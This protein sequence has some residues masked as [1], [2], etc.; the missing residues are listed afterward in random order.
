MSN[1]YFKLLFFTAR[2]CLIE[3]DI[4]GQSETETPLANKT[5]VYKTDKRK[6]PASSKLD[7][8]VFLWYSRKEKKKEQK[9]L[10]YIFYLVLA[11]GL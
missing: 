10:T 8:D 11:E 4:I 5:H 2:R 7:A 6:L 1:G 9:T 3:N